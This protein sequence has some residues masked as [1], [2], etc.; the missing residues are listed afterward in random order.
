MIQQWSHC[1]V[2][3]GKFS[4]HDDDF[5][6]VKHHGNHSCELKPRKLDINF[7]EVLKDGIQKDPTQ[8][9]KE[10]LYDIFKKRNP[11]NYLKK[12]QMIG[13]E[14]IKQNWKNKTI[15]MVACFRAL[16]PE[17]KKRIILF[18]YHYLI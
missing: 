5:A 1:H 17:N 7:D 2:K 12:L 13:S 14:T 11:W 4:F 8:L 18:I 16:L 3:H 15:C 9:Q 10:H 6:I